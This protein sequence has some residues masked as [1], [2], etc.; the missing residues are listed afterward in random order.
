MLLIA[1]LFFFCLITVTVVYLLQRRFKSAIYTCA[2]LL[3]MLLPTPLGISV[4]LGNRGRE[5]F[6]A[7]LDMPA[8]VKEFPIFVKQKTTMP[9]LLPIPT[10]TPPHLARLIG[11]GRS[12]L[13]GDPPDTLNI[14]LDHDVHFCL[15]HD[16]TRHEWILE[17]N[18]RREFAHLADPPDV[19]TTHPTSNP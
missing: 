8:L 13:S 10:V 12:F 18:Y 1:V 19:L 16:E 9:W 15:R 17:N 6:L 3:L 2:L 11:E 14:V 4:F 5:K 7:E